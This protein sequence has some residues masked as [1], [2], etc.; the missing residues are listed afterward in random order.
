MNRIPN[1]RMTDIDEREWLAQ[2][3]AL[4]D[5][6]NGA[7]AGDD[8]LLASYR[9]VAHALRA[10]IA[11]GL[12]ADFART[13]AIRCVEAGATTRVDLRLEQRLQRT[14]VG[15]FVLAGFVAF[16]VYGGDWLQATRVAMPIFGNGAAINW[17]TALTAC[18]AL[19]WAMETIRRR[20]LAA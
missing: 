3:H 7:A 1:D 17:A 2:E 4:R 19:S 10:P 13:I 8:P 9:T 18:V 5:E 12:P 15:V 6:R 20:A 16:A 14:L 11:D